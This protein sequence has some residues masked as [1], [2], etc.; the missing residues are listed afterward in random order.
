MGSPSAHIIVAPAYGKPAPAAQV[1]SSR[2]VSTAVRRS[3]GMICTS[4][5]RRVAPHPSTRAEAPGA[6]AAACAWSISATGATGAS[7]A[8]ARCTRATS[9]PISSSVK[10]GFH[11]RLVTGIRWPPV[12]DSAV[13]PNSTSQS[14]AL[15]SATQCA[16]VR[17]S[18]GAISEPVQDWPAPGSTPRAIS[19]PMKG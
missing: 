6:A 2:S 18:V 7:G 15:V 13:C 11:D 17:N 1:G 16:A 14:D 8:R 3:S 12:P 9:E 10:A 19:A 5:S 4:S